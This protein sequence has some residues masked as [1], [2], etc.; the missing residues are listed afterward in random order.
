MSR[1][2]LIIAH[3]SGRVNARHQIQVKGQF[4]PAVL[5]HAR[6]L[7]IRHPPFNKQGTG[8]VSQLEMHVRRGQFQLVERLAYEQRVW[9]V[10]ELREDIRQLAL[11][12]RIYRQVINVNRS[13]CFVICRPEMGMDENTAF[14]TLKTAYPVSIKK[15]KPPKSRARKEI[16]ERISSCV[17]IFAW[18]RARIYMVKTRNFKPRAKANVSG[19]T[20]TFLPPPGKSEDGSKCGT[21]SFRTFCITL[22]FSCELAIL[23]ARGRIRGFSNRQDHGLND[24]LGPNPI[25]IDLQ[26]ENR[27]QAIHKLI[28]QLVLRKKIKAEHRDAIA[29]G[30]RKRETSMDTGVGFGIGIPHAATDL[31]GGVSQ[32]DWT[33]AQ[34]SSIRLV[35][36]QAECLTTDGHGWTR[37]PNREIREI[38]ELDFRIYFSLPCPP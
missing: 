38:R 22:D 13:G 10:T 3:V 14:R 18:A 12:P 7:A 37:I 21:D 24:F 15:D 11:G 26:A 34:R 20:D 5:H 32:G 35:G 28:D 1:T 2:D 27:W 6:Q 8:F 36:R 4:H 9:N 19:Q 33:F 30:V 29:E 25:V 17:G 16:T 31:V 23:A